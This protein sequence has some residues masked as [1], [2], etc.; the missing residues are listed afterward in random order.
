MSIIKKKKRK[1]S[2][3]LHST[4]PKNETETSEIKK[5]NNIIYLFWTTACRFVTWD[6]K[7]NVSSCMQELLSLGG[8]LKKKKKASPW[9]RLAGDCHSGEKCDCPNFITSDIGTSNPLHLGCLA[10]SL[11]SASCY[12]TLHRQKPQH[13]C[14]DT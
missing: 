12:P 2:L 14:S 10:G 3:F 5:R 7:N 13:S 1:K 4:S 6:C 11:F 8:K 9:A